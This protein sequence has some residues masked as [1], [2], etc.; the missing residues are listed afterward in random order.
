MK[1]VVSTDVWPNIYYE[2]YQ[3]LITLSVLLSFDNGW[4]CFQFVSF[5]TDDDPHEFINGHFKV[6]EKY[7]FSL[8]LISGK[9]NDNES[10]KI[11]LVHHAKERGI[12]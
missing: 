10:L 12:S 5:D 4:F 3:K 6:C 7:T 1:I 8:K 2:I 11:F 9:R